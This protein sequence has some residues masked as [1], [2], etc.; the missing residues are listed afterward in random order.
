M[1]RERIPLKKFVDD[2]GNMVAISVAIAPNPLDRR[3]SR[4]RKCDSKAANDG[5][6]DNCPK[7]FDPPMA[8]SNKGVRGQPAGGTSK[9]TRSNIQPKVRLARVSSQYVKSPQMRRDKKLALFIYIPILIT[10]ERLPLRNL[11]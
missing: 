2:S 6:E 5:A 4:K 1:L 9:R 11:R 7:S 3:L 8:S 10:P